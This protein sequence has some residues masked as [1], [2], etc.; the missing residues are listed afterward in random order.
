M[1]RLV[2]MMVEFFVSMVAV[3]FIILFPVS[4]VSIITWFFG[5]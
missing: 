4:I 1:K 2:F 3:A 5:M